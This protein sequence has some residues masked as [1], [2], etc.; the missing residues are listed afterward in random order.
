MK[1]TV[2]NVDMKKVEVTPETTPAIP[3]VEEPKA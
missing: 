1:C 2:C 3:Q